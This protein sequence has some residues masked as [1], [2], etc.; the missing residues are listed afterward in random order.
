[1]GLRI[2]DLSLGEGF[3]AVLLWG[4]IDNRPF[5]HRMHGYGLCLWRLG[6]YDEAGRIFEKMLWLDP[7]DNQGV[8]FLV[9]EVRAGMA[10]EKRRDQR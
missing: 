4:H 1:M 6:R 7:S 9:D 2:G 10:W 8:R 5:L 3:E